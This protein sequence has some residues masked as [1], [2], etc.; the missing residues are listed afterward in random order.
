MGQ[1]APLGDAL[2][3]DAK[4]LISSAVQHWVSW[5]SPPVKSTLVSGLPARRRSLSMLVVV[6]R[7][8]P[9]VLGATLWAGTLPC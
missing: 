4:V 5:C 8:R 1:Y 9:D 2:P 7:S 6:T 3:D